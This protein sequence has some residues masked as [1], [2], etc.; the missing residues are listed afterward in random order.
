[1]KTSLIAVAMALT[2]VGSLHAEIADS[3]SIKA[4]EARAEKL[5]P[6]W[7]S[8]FFA[9]QLSDD[10]RRSMEVLY[11]YMPLPDITDNSPEFFLENVDMALRARREM[12]W[13]AMVPDREFRHFVLPVRINNEELDGYRRVFYDELKPRVEHLSM[14]D[15]I[16]EINHWCHEKATYQPSDGRTHSPLATVNSAIGRCGEESTF[17]VAALRTMG[18]P[19]RQVYT[20]RWA[21]T[22]DNHAWV[23]A[24]ADGKWYFLGA[25]EPEAILNLGWFNAPAARGMMMHTRVLGKYYGPEEVIERGDTYTDINVTSNYAPTA[26]AHVRVVDTDGTPVEGARVNFSLYNYAEFYP[27]CLRTTDAEGRATLNTGLG[28][29]IVWANYKGRYGFAKYSTGKDGEVT[30]TLLP[31][32]H[33]PLRESIDII[34]PVARAATAV[35]TPEAAALNQ[36]RFVR[37]DS[38]RNAYTST[39]FTPEQ[40]GALARTLGLDSAEVAA[41]MT[42]ARGNH[43]TLREFL[44]TTPK[45]ERPR[46]MR[47]LQSMLPKDRS[48]VSLAILRDHMGAPEVANRDLEPYV[49]SPRVLRETLTPYRHFFK[50]NIPASLQR[51]ARKNP[52]IWADWVGANVTAKEYW[53][54]GNLRMSPISV[55]KHRKT[56]ATSRDIFFVAG[57]RSMGIPAQIDPVTGKTQWADADGTWHDA[58]F[59][60]KSKAKTEVPT[61]QQGT[62]S[63]VYDTNGSIP[64]PKYYTH[65]TISSLDDGEPYLLGYPE[66]GTWSNLFKEPT[67]IDAGRYLIVSGQR[68]ANGGVL[69]TARTFEVFPGKHTTDTLTLRHDSN[70]VEVIGQFNAENRYLPLVPATASTS[71][72]APFTPAEAEKSIISTT[73]RGYYILGLINP[74][75]EPSNH[76]LRDIAAVSAQLEK[77]GNRI[78]LMFADESAASRYNLPATVKLPATTEFGIDPSGA[79]ASEM[80][81]N[82]RLA[83]DERPVFIIADTFNRV[84]FLSQGYTIGLGQTLLDTLNRIK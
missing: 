67:A 19:A 73:G 45:G 15:A 3:A 81:S 14:A 76:A 12:P 60:K 40:S 70:A 49:L 1:M 7:P 47:L 77:E 69:A 75:H 83:S 55:W 72:N 8:K 58:V 43:A 66:D 63:L 22:D 9:R 74:N 38:I 18:I 65:F 80:R 64:D 35:P 28:D 33:A 51:Q 23:E 57:A 11:A 71:G 44:M 27:I 32:D 56:D 4:F 52:Q 2:T 42:D 50:K 16:L 17:T 31:K 84:V 36:C 54:P 30:V 6:M 48:D 25:C 26:T 82:L 24:W 34:P 59:A 37:E 78:M 61:A 20:P 79:I 5:A 29:M 21:H 41:V 10:Q 46:A 13:G 62:F 68:L 39:F 53:Q